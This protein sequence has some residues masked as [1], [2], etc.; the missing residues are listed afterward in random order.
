[1]GYQVIDF[2]DGAEALPEL[3]SEQ[4]TAIQNES[5]KVNYVDGNFQATTNGKTYKNII[6]I[7][8]RTTVETGCQSGACIQY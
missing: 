7:V 4:Q 8:D 3:Q 2:K 6:S 1:M 5:W